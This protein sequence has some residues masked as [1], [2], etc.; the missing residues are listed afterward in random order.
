MP[1][2]HVQIGGAAWQWTMLCTIGVRQ[3]AVFRQDLKE[4]SEEA[5]WRSGSREFY[6]EG[7]AVETACNAKYEANAG[8]ENR[9][10]DDDW[11]SQFDR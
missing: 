9:K 6:T 2:G 4:A 5:D 11:S 3:R 10:A 8:F 1:Q 7:T